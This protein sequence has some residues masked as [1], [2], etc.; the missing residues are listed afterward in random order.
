MLV[1]QILTNILV[2]RVHRHIMKI[3]TWEYSSQSYDLY[4]YEYIAN[5]G[6]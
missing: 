6:R 4:P 3:K 1:N 5:L 2:S